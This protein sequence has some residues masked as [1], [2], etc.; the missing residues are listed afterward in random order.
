MNTGNIHMYTASIIRSSLLICMLTTFCTL[1]Q[2]NP[3]AN[4]IAQSRWLPL[5]GQYNYAAAIDVINPLRGYHRW[6][7]QE[8]IPQ[9]QP[10]MD[11]YQ[12][13][14][15]RTL[16]PVQD[17]YDFSRMLNDLATAKSQGR[18]FAFRIRMMIGYD[19][20]QVYFPA[21]LVNHPQCTAGCGW[22]ADY[23]VNQ[24][25]LTWVPDWNDTFLLDR[26]QAL[27]QALAQ[28]LAPHLGD[29]AWMDIGMYGQYGE[30]V[31]SSRINYSAAPALIT[32]AT[33]Q[34]KRR[35][36]ELQVAALP[37]VQALMFA[38]YG[39]YQAIE[40]AFY[41]QTYSQRPVG[42]RIDCLGRAT[43]M[44][45]W[46]NRPAS[47]ELIR[48]RWHIAPFIA[49]FCPFDLGRQIGIHSPED[50]LT[51]LRDFHISSLSN[52]NI[53]V[54][55]ADFNASEQAAFLSMGREAGYRYALKNSEFQLQSSG[56][57]SLL[58]NIENSGNAPIYEPHRLYLELWDSQGQLRFSHALPDSLAQS[59]GN[60][61]LQ[62][63]NRTLNL[64]TDLVG[65][66]YELRLRA[67]TRL[68]DTR[69]Y[70]MKWANQEANTDGSVTLGILRSF[71]LHTC[72]A[73]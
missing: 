52:G 71:T 12:R 5:N 56:A 51:T 7:N 72:P 59:R 31:L 65:G 63:I 37:Q 3:K 49:E 47:Y 73:R 23:D 61:S 13:Y 24:A 43:F 64:P 41:Q 17:Q 55:F 66:R 36:V 22:W 70:P 42:L 18:R 46:V 15:W 1:L 57:L 50:A 60:M 35:L 4:P 68:V 44:D 30:W 69:S 25:G 39:N 8:R 32:P 29:I 9:T 27:F 28:A 45:Q 53:G 67:E 33:E 6:R 38:L 2:A 21:Y 54:N 62:T 58:I 19:D 14:E 11:A 16:E 40:Y 20:N 48:E 26:A 34:S 10:A